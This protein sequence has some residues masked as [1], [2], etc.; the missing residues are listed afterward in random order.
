MINRTDAKKIESEDVAKFL[1]SADS[2]SNNILELNS[3]I[4]LKLTLEEHEKGIIIKAYEKFN[5]NQHKT[6]RF[7]NMSFQA[8]QYKLKKYQIRSK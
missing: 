2:I 7:L 8:L 6:A 1:K 3:P 4:D 5:K